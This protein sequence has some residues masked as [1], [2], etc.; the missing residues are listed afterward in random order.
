MDVHITGGLMV[1]ETPVELRLLI[2][3]QQIE[4]EAGLETSVLVGSE[5]RSFAPYLAEDLAGAVWCATEGHANP[6][7]AA[8][9]F[10]LRASQRGAAVRTHAGVT[11]VEAHD[12]DAAHRFSVSTTRGSIRAHRVVNASGAW[13]NDIA[14]LSGLRFPMRAEGLHLNVSEPRARVL[15]PMVQ[16]IGRRLTLKQS[17]NTFIIGG[18]WPAR[19]ELAP[20]R[21]STTWAS[22]AGN[23]AVALRVMPSLADVRIVRTWS[24]VM[25]FTDDLSPIVGE[26]AR[27]R[28]YHALIATTGF[29]LGPLMA[30]LLAE[31]MASSDPRP[32]PDA[33]S[34]D[35][36]F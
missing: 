6:L 4:Q 28:G 25:A 33:F 17:K 12:R 5:L 31:Q 8:P 15:E 14:A 27:L 24:G 32:L 29:T 22:A 10:A 23:T 21:Y 13:A 11:A 35:R 1:A 19:P 16:H 2:D 26:T 30:R 36:A 34:A 3:K 20:A 7:L 18:G 9:L